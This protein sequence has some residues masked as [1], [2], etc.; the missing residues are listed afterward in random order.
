MIVFLYAFRLN[1]MVV[2]WHGLNIVGIRLMSIYNCE[3]LLCYYNFFYSNRVVSVWHNVS[4]NK[5]YVKQNLI[6]RMT[7]IV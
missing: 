6:L 3:F 5:H 7:Q 2:V 1:T 4:L